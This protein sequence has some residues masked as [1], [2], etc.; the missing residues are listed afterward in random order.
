[1]INQ[2]VQL[3]YEVPIIDPEARNGINYETILLTR[4]SACDDMIVVM[5]TSPS[6]HCSSNLSL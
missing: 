5:E 1:M 2:V 4:Y 6:Y 3:A